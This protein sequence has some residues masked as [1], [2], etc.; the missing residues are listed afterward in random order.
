LVNFNYSLQK[1]RLYPFL[2]AIA[3][4][5]HQGKRTVSLIREFWDTCIRNGNGRRLIE[6]SIEN[7]LIIAN[8]SYTRKEIN[9][10]TR[11]VYKADQKNQL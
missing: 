2:N 4:S 6:H 3:F 10:I 11:E 8:T 1:N 7:D 9:K 5:Y